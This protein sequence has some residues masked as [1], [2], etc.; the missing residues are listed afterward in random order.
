MNAAKL[1][2]SLTKKSRSNFQYAFLFLPRD[3]RE[4]I[5]AVYAFCRIVDDVVDLGG[6]VT[7]Q[8]RELGRWREEVARCFEGVPEEPVAQRL[9]EVVRRFAVPRAALEAIIDGVEM[10]LDH[11]NYE[12]FND[13][14][15]YCYRVASAVGLCC[16]QIF[17][18]T[19]LRAREYA[20]NLGV[21]LQLTNIL[22]DVYPDCQH[23][24]VYLPQE[25]LRRFGVV[26]ED[27]RSGNYSDRF[28]GLMSFEARRAVEFYDRAWAVLPAQDA[29]RLFA[30]EIMG[31][32]YFS[33]LRTLQAREFRVFGER[34]TVPVSRKLAIALRYWAGAQLPWVGGRLGFP[35]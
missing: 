15:P 31:R 1:C 34:V 33:L 32:I 24:R 17:G 29:R 18:Y 19:D 35:A 3:Q 23:G 11:S 25:D 21:A 10:D 30:G 26:V 9:A 27:L 14:Y 8:R 5:Y 20:V 16:I 13:L 7:I 28:V 12:T 2:S 4:A 6:D 22:R